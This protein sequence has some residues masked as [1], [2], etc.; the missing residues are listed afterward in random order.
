MQGAVVNNGNKDS[1][2]SAKLSTKRKGRL[3]TESETDAGGEAA[4]SRVSH[5]SPTREKM[6]RNASAPHFVLANRNQSTVF[7]PIARYQKILT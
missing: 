4:K 5:L 7:T 6:P 1:Q 2:L 3:R